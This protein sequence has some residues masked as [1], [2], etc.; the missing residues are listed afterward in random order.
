MPDD[1]D[2]CVDTPNPSQ[3]DTN[4][5]GYGNACDPDY[6][7]DDVVGIPDFNVFRAS[8]GTGLGDPGYNPDC[9]H[10]EPPDDVVGIPDF[11]PPRSYFGGPPGP[12]G[13]DCAGT[14]P[15]P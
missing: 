15:C 4:S 9:D 1:E 11:N 5:D 7:N 14:L 13:L 8:F 3:A 6:N 10:S 12:S 2:N